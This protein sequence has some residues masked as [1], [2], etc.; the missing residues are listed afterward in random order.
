MGHLNCSIW[1]VEVACKKFKPLCDLNKDI[2]SKTV[3]EIGDEEVMKWGNRKKER[4][5]IF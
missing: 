4:K 1:N 3:E 2:K 5:N